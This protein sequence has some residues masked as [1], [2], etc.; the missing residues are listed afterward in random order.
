VA[1]ED[2]IRGKPHPESFLLALDRLNETF[3]SAPIQPRECLVVEDSVGGIQGARAAGMICLA[4]TNSYP[5]E[6][7]QEANEIVNSLEEVKLDGLQR[8]FEEPM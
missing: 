3:D 4:V 6:M 5:R 8:L 1:A 7:L 2:F